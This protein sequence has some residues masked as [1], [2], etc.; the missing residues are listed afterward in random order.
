MSIYDSYYVYAY[1]RKSNFTPYYIGKGKG[2]RI[3]EKHKGISIPKDKFLRVILES[4]LTNLG[5]CA[6]ERRYIRWYGKKDSG[7]GMLINKTDGGDG[8]FSKHTQETKNKFSQ[9]RKGIPRPR[10]K[11][12][13]NK[14]SCNSKF[15]EI[16]TPTGKIEIVKSLNNYCKENFLNYDAMKSVAYGIQN[17]KQHKGYKVKPII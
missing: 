14:L 10:T 4:N 9:Q 12:H 3:N 6:L 1:L 17:R 7:F 13:Q 5:A 8:W 2:N 11:E 15:W 16:I